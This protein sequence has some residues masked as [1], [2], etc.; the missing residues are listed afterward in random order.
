V[1]F[2]QNKWN[3]IT[4]TDYYAYKSYR[5]NV[6]KV[7]DKRIELLVFECWN[8]SNVSKS[9]YKL[10]LKQ[11]NTQN[12]NSIKANLNVS[13][14]NLDVLDDDFYYNVPDNCEITY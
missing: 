5:I 3:S 10:Y 14:N 12:S 1:S 9:I 4:S 7:I 11:L 13:N 6:Q 2:I 8:K